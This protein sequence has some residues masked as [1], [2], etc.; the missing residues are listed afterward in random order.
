MPQIQGV[1][2]WAAT[3]LSRSQAVV[4]YCEPLATRAMGHHPA[5]SGKGKQSE[6]INKTTI[7]LLSLV[8]SEVLKYFGYLS[9]LNSNNSL[10]NLF[11]HS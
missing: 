2:G 9:I 10:F 7:I 5:E 4:N 11:M 8:Y 3:E 1:Q 6:E